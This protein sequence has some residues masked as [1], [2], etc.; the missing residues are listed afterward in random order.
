MYGL[1]PY[2][3]SKIFPWQLYTPKDLSL[4]AEKHPDNGKAYEKTY[5]GY[6]NKEQEKKLAMY[7]DHSIT[8]DALAMG[9]ANKFELEACNEYLLMD[10]GVVP[11]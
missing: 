4:H 8:G 7:I 1:T 5:Q 3:P 2:T 6:F 11:M 9:L 10:V